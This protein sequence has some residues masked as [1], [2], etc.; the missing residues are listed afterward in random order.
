M[1]K[2]TTPEV[3]TIDRLIASNRRSYQVI[4]DGAEKRAE[5]LRKWLDRECRRRD[6]QSEVWDWFRERRNAKVDEAVERML[7]P[8][9][10]RRRRNA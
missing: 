8:F 1:A 10:R 5:R 2:N 7:N 9:A 6:R 4:L 3:S